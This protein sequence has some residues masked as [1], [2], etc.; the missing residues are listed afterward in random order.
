MPPTSKKLRGLIGFGLSVRVSVR[1]SRPVHARVLKFHIWIPHGNT[2][3]TRFYAPH[4]EEVEGHI[5]LG[6]CVSL[7]MRVLLRSGTVRD[8]ILKF[9]TYV[10]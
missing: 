10:K 9:Y 3:D 7:S 1:S 4:F 8:M 2:A 6:L 5:G